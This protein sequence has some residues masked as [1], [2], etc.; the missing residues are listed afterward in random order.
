MVMTGGCFV[1]LF[2]PPYRVLSENAGVCDS[3]IPGLDMLPICCIM[4]INWVYDGVSTIFCFFFGNVLYKLM[5]KGSK[6]ILFVQ[7]GLR[8]SHYI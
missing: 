7:S 3:S 5:K 4:D 6:W 1:A 8:V 2:F